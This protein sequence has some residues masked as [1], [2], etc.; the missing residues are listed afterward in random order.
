M[1]SM[2][3]LVGRSDLLVHLDYLDEAEGP[4]TRQHRKTLLYYRNSTGS[5][6]KNGYEV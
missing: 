3:E 5:G 1:K 4:S 2:K 6:S